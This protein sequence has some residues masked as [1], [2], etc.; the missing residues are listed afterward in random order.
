MKQLIALVIFL[1]LN[2]NLIAAGT[3]SS[4]L[5]VPIE[6]KKVVVKLEKDLGRQLTR[7]ETLGAE[8][9]KL[10]TEINNIKKD[11]TWSEKN[12]FRWVVKLFGGDVNKVDLYNTSFKDLDKLKDTLKYSKKEYEE[13][14]GLVIQ[15]IH[16]WLV[17]NDESYKRTYD[18]ERKLYDI[19]CDGSSCLSS[20]SAAL[21]KN[22]SASNT[23]LID[24]LT[25]NPGVSILSNME[26]N[27]ANNAAK[28]AS[29]KSKKY[30]DKVKK[31]QNILT[32]N[33]V[34]VEHVN[35]DLDLVM[36]LV[37]DMDFDFLSI[38]N[39]FK[40]DNAKKD[41]ISLRND[42][43]SIH[44]KVYQD[45]KMFKEKINNLLCDIR[46]LCSNE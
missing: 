20:I 31:L 36:D 5:R 42:I 33:E 7:T 19:V 43:E 15:A 27:G 11:M 13:M 22:K 24:A 34:S 2:A 26:T 28:K 44:N 45:H 8:V 32:S 10:N 18:V 35:D 14:D 25:N 16:D 21:D 40:L 30:V 1:L 3:C 38:M 9:S 17:K 39:M 6:L 4:N 46:G 41:L 12:L 29:K 37:F 23:E